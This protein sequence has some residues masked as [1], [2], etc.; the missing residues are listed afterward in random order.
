MY[1]CV[2]FYAKLKND[3]LFETVAWRIEMI[4]HPCADN[5]TEKSFKCQILS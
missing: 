3:C 1:I 5:T 4:N 2:Y